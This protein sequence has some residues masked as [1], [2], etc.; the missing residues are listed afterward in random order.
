MNSESKLGDIVNDL[1][2]QCRHEHTE[3]RYKV[4]SGG[5][6]QVATQCLDCGINVDGRW[7]PQTGLDMASLKPWDETIALN[8]QRA[9]ASQR[10]ATLYQERLRRHEEYERYICSSDNWQAVR[11][12]VMKR[13]AYLCQGCL[14]NAAT[15]V[16]HLSYTHLFDEVMFNLVA[17]CRDCHKKIHGRL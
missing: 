8:Y 1:Y 7:L 17:V 6:K 2:P 4:I 12:K 11:T 13:D 16:H 14:E 9:T 15:D 5:R 10:N 3:I